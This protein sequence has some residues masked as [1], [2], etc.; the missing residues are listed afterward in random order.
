METGYKKIKG[1]FV[2]SASS[3]RSASENREKSEEEILVQQEKSTGL[4]NII[5]QIERPLGTQENG[6]K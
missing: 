5:L 4:K 2:R 3:K 6:W 1:Q